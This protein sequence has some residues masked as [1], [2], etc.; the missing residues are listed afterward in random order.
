MAPPRCCASSMPDRTRCFCTTFESIRVRV[1]LLRALKA[2]EIRFGEASV[3]IETSFQAGATWKVIADEVKKGGFEVSL[4]PRRPVH[5]GPGDTVHILRTYGAMLPGDVDSATTT[6]ESFTAVVDPEGYLMVPMLARIR[7]SDADKTGESSMDVDGA[8]IGVPALRRIGGQIEAAYSRV[9]VWAP[10]WHGDDR[11]SLVEI[12]ECLGVGVGVPPSAGCLPDDDSIPA[13]FSARCRRIGVEPQHR[14]CPT[15]ASGV[16]YQLTPAAAVWTLV[17]AA[18]QRMTV[19]YRHGDTVAAGARE[20]YRRLRGTELI[21]GGLR[22]RDAFLTVLPGP[23]ADNRRPFYL[24]ASTAGGSDALILPGD[25]V[26]ISKAV[27]LAAEASPFEEA[28]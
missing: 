6:A 24:L 18:G 1:G 21:H 14:V 27:P 5:V 10:G 19:G 16:H 15:V 13:D 20:H 12:G 4:R 11:P 23:H 2:I 8:K 17:D 26:V 3:I 7:F 9:R 25:T 22:H 28:R